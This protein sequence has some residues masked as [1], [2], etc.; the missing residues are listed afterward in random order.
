M[1]QLGLLHPAM[2]HHGSDRVLPPVCFSALLCLVKDLFIHGTF[3]SLPCDF[4]HLVALMRF[5]RLI[6]RCAAS[7]LA[8]LADVVSG[9]SSWLEVPFVVL[10]L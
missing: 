1:G 5:M 7:P 6:V 4:R 10:R 8:R 2:N 9:S 3:E